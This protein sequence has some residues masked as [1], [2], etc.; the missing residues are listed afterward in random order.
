MST[1]V[2]HSRHQIFGS[3]SFPLAQYIN[4]LPK[5]VN[6]RVLTSHGI[7]LKVHDFWIMDNSVYMRILR[8]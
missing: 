6:S 3:L 8:R 1:I 2:H 4:A 5:D 7:E